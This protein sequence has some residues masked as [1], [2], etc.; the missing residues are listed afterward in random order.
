MILHYK[1]TSKNC[2][3]KPCK[4]RKVALDLQQTVVIKPYKRNE[5]IRNYYYYVWKLL[6][7]YVTKITLGLR[8]EVALYLRLAIE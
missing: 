3:L 6:Q 1:V 4:Q 5:K 2:V 8:L 7:N